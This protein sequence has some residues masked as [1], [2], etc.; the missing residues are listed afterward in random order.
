MTEGTALSGFSHRTVG[1]IAAAIP[2][3]TAV[4]RRF[5]LDFCCGGT[6]RLDEA[7][8]K[9]GV[10]L[11][12]INRALAELNLEAGVVAPRETGPLID[13]ILQ[14]FHEIHRA[15][16]PAL[17]RL[18]RKV[19]EVHAGH[20]QAPVGLGDALHRMGLELESHMQKEELVLFPLMQDCD[21]SPPPIIRHPIAQMRHEHDEHGRHIAELRALTHDLAL[22]SDA[23][24]SWQALYAGL[25]KLIDDL[26]EH[27][28]LENNL[29]FPRFATAIRD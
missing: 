13:H 3:A 17:L 21:G 4:F 29:L 28:H 15:E 14:R 10:D 2:G 11:A 12:A 20:P 26:M 22:P 16:V 19:E 8:S 6:A 9:R 24:R 5:D 1:E 18:A 7:A 25:G 27:I 23:C